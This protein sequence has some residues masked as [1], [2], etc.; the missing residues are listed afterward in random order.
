VAPL[1]QPQYV[2]LVD[3]QTLAPLET[4][5]RAGLLAI[6]AYLGKT[7]LIDNLVLRSRRPIIA[8]DGPAGAGKSTVA[9]LVAEELELLYLDS[10]AMYRAV[11][12]RVM[13]AGIAPSDEVAVAEL[14][15]N[16]DIRLGAN[17]SQGDQPSPSRV[18]VNDEEVTQAIRTPTVTAQVSTV[19]AQPMVRQVLL[20]Q[21]QA[22]GE[23]GG[24]VM[25]GRDIGTHVFPAAELKIFLTASVQERARRRQQD[26]ANQ[27]QPALSLADLERAIDA[28]DRKD[29]T[30][31]VAPLRKAEGAIELVTDGLTIEQ[32]VSKIV[33]LYHQ[34]LAPS[35]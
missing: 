12:W 21:Q 5:Q 2:E 33:G 8:I 30:R 27:N 1:V 20:R 10:G 19:A 4:L 25:E 34:A 7:R 3:L 6:A 18:W 22:Y 9:R 29:S 26:L 17:P 16:C 15:S 24:L 13:Q 31:R 28:R 32:V 35:A 23:A 11:T 14:L